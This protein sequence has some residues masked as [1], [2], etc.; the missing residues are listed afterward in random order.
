MILKAKRYAYEI[1]V[2]DDGSTDNTYEVE[3]SSG[4]AT[5]IKS[6]HNRGYGT[7]IGA[8]FG[9]SRDK[10]AEIKVTLDSDGQHHAQQISYLIK[11]LIRGECDMV[12]GSMFLNTRYVVWRDSTSGNGEYLF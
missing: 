9:A 1:I 2:Y 5:V 10:N 7:A 11:P 8:L 12:I 4:A 6:P 3:K